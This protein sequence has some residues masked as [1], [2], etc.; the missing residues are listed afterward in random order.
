V[1]LTT[2]QL[3]FADG[4]ADRAVILD[5]GHI[6]DAGPFQ[7]VVTGAEAARLGLR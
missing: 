5:Q 3:G 7:R 6:A 2:H 4:L 1:V